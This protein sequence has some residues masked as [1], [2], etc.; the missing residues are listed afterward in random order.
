MEVDGHLSRSASAELPLFD[1]RLKEQGNRFDIQLAELCERQELQRR[2]DKGC[3][4]LLLLPCAQQQ[5]QQ[6]QQQDKRSGNQRKLTADDA[7]PVSGM[8]F[9]DQHPRS[10]RANSRA[11][12]LEW[13]SYGEP[14]RAL[15]PR[16][17]EEA[18]ETGAHSPPQ[19]LEKGDEVPRPGGPVASAYRPRLQYRQRVTNSLSDEDDER[20][21]EAEAARSHRLSV[22]R[23]SQKIK[24]LSARPE[25]GER[26]AEVKETASPTREEHSGCE[27]YHHLPYARRCRMSIDAAVK[28]VLL[29]LPPRSASESVQH[30]CRALWEMKRLYQEGT[31]TYG[32]SLDTLLS[33]PT[34]ALPPPCVALCAA[35]LSDACVSS[36]WGSVVEGL[37][38]LSLRGRPADEAAATVEA[39]LMG[40]L[41][42]Q[43]HAIAHMLLRCR[44]SPSDTSAAVGVTSA[45]AT[46]A[47]GGRPPARVQGGTSS[48]GEWAA[49]PEVP[50]AVA[51]ELG[52]GRVREGAAD[53]SL[54]TGGK[55]SRDAAEEAAV[56]GQRSP[57]W[58]SSASAEPHRTIP[59][60]Y[61]RFFP[62]PTALSAFTAPPPPPPLPSSSPRGT[63]QQQDSGRVPSCRFFT[64]TARQPQ[65]L[66]QRYMNEEG[67][68][69]LRTQTGEQRMITGMVRQRQK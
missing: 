3:V 12:P 39:L 35:Y 62:L 16:L 51:A 9:P 10:R 64:A 66:E 18:A 69:T 50:V 27:F 7:A 14:V 17:P 67:N 48:E 42:L 21:A 6:Q 25:R 37:A 31:R 29:Q 59:T 46:A 1:H 65:L 24:A 63:E 34:G 44:A 68:P 8:P 19:P 23:I 26:S 47:D 38:S 22:T 58:S 54:N 45:P 36:A 56:G 60:P 40:Y 61:D 32:G 5:Q 55:E 13:N 41:S 52:G 15:R 53:P 2:F 57:W 33:L 49:A 20:T 43:S 28:E 4:L 11:P 30:L